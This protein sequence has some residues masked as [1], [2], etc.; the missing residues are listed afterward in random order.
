MTALS[1]GQIETTLD[2]FEPGLEAVHPAHQDRL[3]FLDVG[4][5]HLHVTKI[6]KHA[7][8]LRVHSAQENE[9]N[10]IRFIDHNATIPVLSMFRK[11]DSTTG[12]PQW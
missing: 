4:D 8:N 10:I 12:L 9:D 2:A 3:I 5:A 6:F 1:V 11:S 7:I